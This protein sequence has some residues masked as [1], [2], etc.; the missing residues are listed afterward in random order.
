MRTGVDPD[1]GE[2]LQVMLWPVY[3]HMTDR[4]L[5]AIYAYLTAIP[6]AEPAA[7]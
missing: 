4:D 6:H 7:Q 5:E 3:A 1:S 2:L